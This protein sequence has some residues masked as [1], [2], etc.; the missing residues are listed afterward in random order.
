LGGLEHQ[1]QRGKKISGR[2][3]MEGKTIRGVTVLERCLPARET[4]QDNVQRGRTSSLAF[5]GWIEPKSKQD[6]S[7]GD[8]L[9]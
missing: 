4:E 9:V 5:K 2:S 1:H 3:A 8:E 6:I 7:L